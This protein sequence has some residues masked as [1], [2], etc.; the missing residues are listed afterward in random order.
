[1]QG[2]Q[3]R[4]PVVQRLSTSERV[5]PLAR[6]RRAAA[7]FIYRSH[8]WFGAVTAVAVIAISV[9][10]IYLNHLNTL[11]FW[12]PPEHESAGSIDDAMSLRQIIILGLTAG[13][14]DGLDVNTPR[15]VSRV[16]YRPGPNQ[17]AVRFTDREAHEAVID[18]TT[19]EALQVAPRDDV[20]LEHLHTGEILGQ[21]GVIVS[22]VAAA[23]LVIFTVGGVWLWLNRLLRARRGS[24][25]V[26]RG[27]WMQAN[28]WLHLAG[29]L[30][31]AALVILLS[32]TGVLLNHKRELGFMDE[33]F[34][35]IEYEPQEQEPMPLA[36]I[37]A[38]GITAAADPQI[39][40]V[41]DIRF[42]DFRLPT[43]Y[44]KVRF[45]DGASTEVIVNVYNGRIVTVSE[46]QDFFLEGLHGGDKLGGLW[47]RLLIDASG[48]VLILLTLNG[49]YLWVWPV[50]IGRSRASRGGEPAYVEEIPG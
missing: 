36:D 48:V 14:D 18:A 8:V 24:P 28:R 42:I 13:H 4:P 45:K 39:D 5:S 50:W 17:A 21:R 44:A 19:G 46:R 15:D 38:I 43:G 26:R 1:M 34:Q 9:T 12:R 16:T 11:G 41:N 35:S 37:A 31:V 22:D 30:G 32:V 7:T 10:G 27:W 33:P 29:G 40:A 25:P 20:T 2:T 47:G 6:A 3:S 49:L 23:A